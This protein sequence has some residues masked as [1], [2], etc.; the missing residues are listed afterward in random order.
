MTTDNEPD[1]NKAI[2]DQIDARHS[3]GF[4]N[5]PSGPV[6]QNFGEQNIHFPAL[7]PALHQL[8]APVNDFVGREQEI[9]QLVQALSKAAT[10]GA[11]AAISGVR[12]RY[13]YRVWWIIPVR[14]LRTISRV[15]SHEFG[16]H[17]HCYAAHV[18]H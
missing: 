1:N 11:A 4:I 16:E 18:A 13:C 6:F 3:Q 7:S 14:P 8:R 12:G 5:Q 9:D 15:F 17:T 2:G 10:S